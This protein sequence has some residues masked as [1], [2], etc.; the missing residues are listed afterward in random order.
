MEMGDE[1]VRSWKEYTVT[2][3]REDSPVESINVEEAAFGGLLAE[4]W[5]GS[6]SCCTTT[7]CA[8]CTI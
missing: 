7:L 6:Y 5:E 2:G 1:V 8:G 3:V 4:S